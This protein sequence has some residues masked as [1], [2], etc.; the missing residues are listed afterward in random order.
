MT[1]EQLAASID[2]SE[3]PLRLSGQTTKE[4]AAAN[5][6]IV[7]G[8]SDDLTEFEGAICDELDAFEG[9]THYLTAEGL[10]PGNQCCEDDCPNY[11]PPSED[12]A[13][14]LKAIWCPDEEKSWAFK[15]GIPYATFNI[16][17]DGGVYC[18]GIVFSMDVVAAMLG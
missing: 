11:I 7:Y 4:A 3:Y 6:V 8:A 10:Y 14:T 5:L 1:K 12:N 18:E 2:G 16:M 15:T 9:A 13:V 17:E